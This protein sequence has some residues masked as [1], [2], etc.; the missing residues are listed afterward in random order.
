MILRKLDLSVE[1]S[2]SE[3][4]LKSDRQ[5]IAALECRESLGG[6]ADILGC[7]L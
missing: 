2:I 3:S 5:S 6:V 7:V 1:P 4:P